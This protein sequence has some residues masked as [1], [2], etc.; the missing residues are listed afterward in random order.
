VNASVLFLKATVV[1]AVAGVLARLLQRRSAAERHAVWLI[2]FGALLVLPF[3]VLSPVTPS[4]VTYSVASSAMSGAAAK[5]AYGWA[6]AIW[7]IG[8]AVCMLRIVVAS[9]MAFR[10][11][12]ESHG[13]ARVRYSSRVSSPMA[14]GIGTRLTLLPPSAVDWQDELRRVVL[15]HEASHLR[16]NDCWALLIAEIACALY[17]CNPLVWFAARELRREQEHAADDEVLIQGV[18]PATYA[19]HLVALARSQRAPL[20]AAGA[21]CHSDLK[22]RVESILEQGRVRTMLNRRRVLMAAVTLVAIAVP[23]AAMQARK[24]YKI[25]GDVTPPKLLVKNE[26]T[27]TDAARDAKIQGAVVLSVIIEATGRIE[28]VTVVRS[29]D[30]DLDANAIT[31][32]RTWEFAPA[33][34]NGEPVA[35]TANIEVNFRLQ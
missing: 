22:G 3:G 14:W 17:W 6:A 30:P 11:I 23:L 32:V 9:V 10:I 18:D 5:A 16:R 19:E 15:L 4:S 12:R 28:E 34:R 2:T 13:D 35:V 27:Y 7:T 31:A 24:T 25:G 8:F 1:V 29:L 33:Q 26:P 20:L 21:V